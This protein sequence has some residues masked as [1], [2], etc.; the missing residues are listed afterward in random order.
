VVKDHPQ[1]VLH[2]DLEIRAV[3]G[4][5]GRRT[6]APQYP[7]RGKVD[8]AHL[9]RGRNRCAVLCNTHKRRARLIHAGYWWERTNAIPVVDTVVHQ[10]VFLD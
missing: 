6:T 7:G 8:I 10:R 2:D 3:L 4:A 1:P 9:A 5:S